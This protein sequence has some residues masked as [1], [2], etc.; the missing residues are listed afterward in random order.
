MW[1]GAEVAVYERLKKKTEE[2]QQDMPA[3]VKKII[4]RNL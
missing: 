3:Y 1:M 4:E 2:L